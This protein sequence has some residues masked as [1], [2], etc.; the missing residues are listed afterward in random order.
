M[1]EQ[2]RVRVIALVCGGVGVVLVG[3]IVL[4]ATRGHSQA[5][6]LESPL[7]GH[8][9]PATSSVTLDGHTVS[10]EAYRGRPLVINF[11]ASWCPPCQQEA[12][13]LA[14][15]EYD[16]SLKTNGAAIVG[17]IFNDADA[18][19]RRFV[20]SEGVNYPVL[21]DPT[22]GIANAWGVT[23]PPTTFIVNARGVVVSALVGPLTATQL[24]KAVASASVTGGSGRG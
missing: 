3:L 1:S 9:A 24:D 18:A 23:S 10:I 13:Q 14:A 19:V 4:L 5:T 7:L 6:T 22:G 15:F 2:R 8:E 12:P 16:Q 21:T 17:V 20:S 11:F